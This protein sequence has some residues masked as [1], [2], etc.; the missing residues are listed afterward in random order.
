MGKKA[1]FLIACLA[2][3]LGGCSFGAQLPPPAPTPEPT[4]APT[5]EPTPAPTEWTVT[6]EGPEEILAL[7][8]IASLQ[9]VDAR[10]SAEYDA[11][12]RLAAL[13]KLLAE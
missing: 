3:L 13:R 2:L 10:A 4:P 6:D 5:P 12:L 8:E 1:L 9:T 7:A 11:L